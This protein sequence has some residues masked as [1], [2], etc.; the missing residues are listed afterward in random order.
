M[1]ITADMGS[2]QRLPQLVGLARARMLAM[3]CKIF[4]GDDAEKMGLALSSFRTLEELQVLEKAFELDV[5]KQNFTLKFPSFTDSAFY[6]IM[7]P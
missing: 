3:T 4:T 5:V 2:L 1:A 6:V 7:I